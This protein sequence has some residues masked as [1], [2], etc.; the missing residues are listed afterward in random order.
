MPADTVLARKEAI[1]LQ[2]TKALQTCMVCAGISWALAHQRVATCSLCGHKQYAEVLLAG[3]MFV[4]LK[5]WTY[6]NEPE[7]LNMPVL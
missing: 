4:G 7:R 1:G 6:F 3:Q 5:S 2:T